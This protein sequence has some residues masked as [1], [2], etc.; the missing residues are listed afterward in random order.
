M[1]S[2]LLGPLVVCRQGSLHRGTASE[3]ERRDVEKEFA[4]LFMV[5]DENLSWY[6]EDNILTY[7]NLAADSDI[8]EVEDFYDSNKKYSK[9]TPHIFNRTRDETIWP[10]YIQYLELYPFLLEIQTRVTK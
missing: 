6:L 4:L 3:R 9:Y 8:K 5:F 10:F 1:N 7:L 2:G